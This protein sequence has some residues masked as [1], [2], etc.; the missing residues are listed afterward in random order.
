MAVSVAFVETTLVYSF[1]HESLSQFLIDFCFVRQ[2][3]F[4]LSR[5][6]VFSEE[7]SRFYGAEITCA[8][9]YLHEKNIVYRDLKVSNNV[10]VTACCAPCLGLFHS[11]MHL[12]HLSFHPILLSDESGVR[13]DHLSVTASVQKIR[14]RSFSSSY[15]LQ[16]LLC[17]A[18]S[19]SL[20]TPWCSSST[21]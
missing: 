21:I 16:P 20:S 5:E 6:R 13:D 7:R 11:L 12:F 19:L 4:H 2:L 15:N 17:T 3:F 1:F 18:P 9:K 10:K 14:R 8:L